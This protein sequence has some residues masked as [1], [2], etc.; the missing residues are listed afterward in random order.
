VFKRFI[1]CETFLRVKCLSKRI[2]KTGLM[3]MH[4]DYKPV[5]LTKSQWLLWTRG[6]RGLGMNASCG[7]AM[8]VYNR[9][10]GEKL[11]HKTHRG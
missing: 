9:V 2:L 4:K 1:D 10:T 6:E 7:W 3:H 11:W 5:F 8:H